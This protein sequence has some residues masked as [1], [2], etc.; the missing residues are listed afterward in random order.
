[1]ASF[2]ELEFSE[3]GAMA[4]T[5]LGSGVS[6]LRA[7]FRENPDF[8]RQMIRATRIADF[9][10]QSLSMFGRGDR[11]ELLRGLDPLWPDESLGVFAES[12]VA[13]FEN[14]PHFSAEAVFQSLD[15]RRYDTI[16]SVSYPPKLLHSSRL[17]VGI[18]DVTSAKKARAAEERS[19]RRY[20]DFFHFLPVSL[21]QLEGREVVGLFEQARAQG[22]ADFADYLKE[23]PDIFARAL[24]GLKIVE[25]NRRTVEM[26]RAKSADEFKG[27][28]TRYWTESPEVH[29][30]LARGTLCRQAGLRGPGQDAR[31]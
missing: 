16:F 17:L 26:F 7:H 1:M 5:L 29:S 13:A 24:G 10:E 14:K 18:I 3:V 15:G 31:P 9:N 11:G 6:D 8:V 27:P 2:W 30:R 22:V 12:V 23:H 25:V 4:R 28:V 19:E 20:R 21:L